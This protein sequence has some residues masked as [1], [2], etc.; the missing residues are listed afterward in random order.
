MSF[1]WPHQP[2]KTRQTAKDSPCLQPELESCTTMAS[3][4]ESGDSELESPDR[5]ALSLANDKLSEP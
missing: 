4:E 2:Y 1:P 3:V 5:C